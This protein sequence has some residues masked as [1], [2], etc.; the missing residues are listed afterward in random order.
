MGNDIERE[1][2]GMMNREQ[3][4][5]LKLAEECSEVVQIA[6][7]TMQFGGTER[8]PDLKENNYERTYA[9]LNDVW[10]IIEMLNSG[11]TEFL[12]TKN[13]EVIEAKKEK[14]EK[15]LKFSQGLGMVVL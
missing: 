7:K 8:R 11:K 2:E 13:R 9:E 3:F 10:A 6:S 1:G 4:L 5:L 12:F 15:Y 14:V